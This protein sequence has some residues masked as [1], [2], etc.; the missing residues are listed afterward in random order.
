MK[1]SLRGLLAELEGIRV[2]INI[3]PKRGKSKHQPQQTVLTR[4]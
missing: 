3:Y 4:M 1:I 2:V